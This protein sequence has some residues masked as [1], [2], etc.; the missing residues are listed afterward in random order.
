MY[1]SD[2]VY[3]N[4]ELTYSTAGKDLSLSDDYSQILSDLSR[5]FV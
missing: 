2:N 1:N 4:P 3:E 5:I